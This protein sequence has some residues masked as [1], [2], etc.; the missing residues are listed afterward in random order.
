MAGVKVVKLVSG[1]GVVMNWY[2][3]G[4]VVLDWY[5]GCGRSNGSVE[6]KRVE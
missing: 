5:G 3:G 1:E 6:W 4:C 2:V